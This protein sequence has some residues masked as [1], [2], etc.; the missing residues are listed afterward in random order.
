[1]SIENN[2]ITIGFYHQFHRDYIND[3]KYK[4]LVEKKLREV[5]DKPYKINCV[6]ME[7]KK[8]AKEPAKQEK[9]APSPLTEIAL[10]RGAKIIGQKPNTEET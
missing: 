9:D 4:F 2:V 10:K 6:I 3:P 5:F 7:R 1:L 8:E